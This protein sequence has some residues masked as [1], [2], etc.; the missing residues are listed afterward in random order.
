[1]KPFIKEKIILGI[2]PGTTIMGY[3]VLKVT[4]NKAQMV[5][6]GIIDLRKYANHYLK[7][8]RIFERVTGIIE[9]YLPDRPDFAPHGFTEATLAVH[10]ADPLIVDA[11]D[12]A[13]WAGARP[14]VTEQAMAYAKSQGLDW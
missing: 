5:A 6:M 14:G 9:A 7:L 8:H 1:M 10:E 3:G 11:P 13:N 4:D 2:D 12:F